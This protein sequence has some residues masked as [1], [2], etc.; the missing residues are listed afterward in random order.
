MYRVVDVS[1]ARVEKLDKKE[2]TAHIELTN[3][4]N[5]ENFTAP[6][7]L[8]KLKYKGVKEVDQ[9]FEYTVYLDQLEHSFGQIELTE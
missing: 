5:D 9:C 8:K 7:D 2:N 6:F 1:R 3:V 4:D